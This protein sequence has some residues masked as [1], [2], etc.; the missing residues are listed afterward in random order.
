V[1]KRLYQKM[2]SGGQ[3]WA[4]VGNRITL[5]ERMIRQSAHEFLLTFKCNYVAIKYRF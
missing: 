1:K 5:A 4:L 2:G 3:K